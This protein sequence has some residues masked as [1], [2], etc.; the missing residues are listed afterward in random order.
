MLEQEDYLWQSPSPSPPTT[1][2]ES[3]FENNSKRHQ[4]D[5]EAEAER[6]SLRR[7]IPC[8]LCATKGTHFVDCHACVASAGMRNLLCMSCSG[9]GKVELYPCPLCEGWGYRVFNPKNE[10]I[11]QQ[12]NSQDQSSDQKHADTKHETDKKHKTVTGENW[13]LVGR[14]C[15][16]C[17]QLHECHDAIQEQQQPEESVFSQTE[18]GGLYLVA[19]VD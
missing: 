11:E 17:E 13:D 3:H 14:K 5:T 6:E 18:G 2:Y 15:P 12:G 7:T 1:R 8:A 16:H 19:R 9:E 10:P 4:E